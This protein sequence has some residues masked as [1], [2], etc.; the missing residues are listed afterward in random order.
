[1]STTYRPTAPLTYQRDL[2]PQP[3]TALSFDPVSDS[4]WAGLASGQV[5]ALHSPR[6]LR[7]VSF[8]VGG[9]MAV[10]KLGAGETYVRALG[11]AGVGV[12]QWSKGG[13]NK[14]HHRYAPKNLSRECIG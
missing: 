2:F 9:A 4:L 1:M 12:G 7:G 14:W 10:K 11:M 6:G 3:V 13:V 5:V 8:P